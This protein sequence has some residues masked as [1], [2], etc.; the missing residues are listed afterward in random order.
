MDKG[1]SSLCS[2]VVSG[3]KPESTNTLDTLV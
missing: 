3:R 1:K 2:K